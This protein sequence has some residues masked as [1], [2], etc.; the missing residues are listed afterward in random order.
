MKLLE[1]GGKGAA[2][3]SALGPWGSLAG[4]VLGF[5]GA[6]LTAAKEAEQLEEQR[7]REDER[8]DWQKTMDKKGQ[9]NTERQLGQNTLQS[10][11]G[12]F[13][14]ALYRALTKG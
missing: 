9:F 10:M 8:F 5:A 13:K 4:G 1:S 3:G 7:W 12:G 11:R 2:T 6:G 14:E